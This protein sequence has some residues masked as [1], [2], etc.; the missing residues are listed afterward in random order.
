VRRDGL[1]R[2]R[3]F[4]TRHPGGI[5]APPGTTRSPCQE[6]ADRPAIAGNG[7][8]GPVL[9]IAAAGAP[10]GARRDPARIADTI[11][12]RFSARHP[13]SEGRDHQAPG[14]LRAAARRAHVWSSRCNRLPALPLWESTRAFWR[15]VRGKQR[16]DSVALRLNNESPPHPSR[17]AT[18]ELRRKIAAGSPLPQ[19][20]RGQRER[21]VGSYDPSGRGT[22]ASAKATR[23][24]SATSAK[25]A[26]A[27]VSLNRR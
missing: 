9:E 26:P 4:A 13:L 10:R 24:R 6:L 25:S 8:R 17:H 18:C 2:L 21:L 16:H 7:K 1:R 11:G 12:L 15:A 3:A 19:G 23:W 5:G 22:P 20:E 14:A 27:M